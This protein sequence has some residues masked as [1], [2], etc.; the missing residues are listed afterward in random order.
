MNYQLNIL[1]LNTYVYRLVV[2]TA[3]MIKTANKPKIDI[4]RFNNTLFSVKFGSFEH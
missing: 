1:Y 4:N 2:K 3:N